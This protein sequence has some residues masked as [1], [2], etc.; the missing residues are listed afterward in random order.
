MPTSHMHLLTLPTPHLS[1]LTPTHSYLSCSGD[2]MFK[3]QK[4]RFLALMQLSQ[5]KF[6]L[7][8]Y[9]PNSAQPKETLLLSEGFTVEYP[10]GEGGCGGRGEEGREE[11]RGEEG[12][13]GRSN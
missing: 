12:G 5:Y 1:L 2:F 6:L 13:E 7:C 9:Y 3:Q 10:S 11:R 4:R 8:A